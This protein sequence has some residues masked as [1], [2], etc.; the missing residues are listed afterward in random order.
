VGSRRDRAE[1]F[2][3]AWQ[4][5]LG[6]SSQPTEQLRLLR[7]HGL[8]APATPSGHAALATT[9]DLP[10]VV[11]WLDAFTAELDLLSGPAAEVA[12]SLL[13]TTYLWRDEHDVPVSL[14]GYHPPAR[15]VSRVGPV[16]T[17]P[18]HRRRGYA[19]A[20]TSA[21][22]QAAYDSGAVDVV[23]YT[24]ATNPTSNAVYERVGYVHE[25]DSLNLRLLRPSD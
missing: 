20:V 21:A 17:P 10:L 22:T 12:Q 16:F 11:E 14:A 7:C 4:A 5:L 15:E 3:A 6:A 1:A 19:G 9:D 24:D 23:L 18:E 8:L 2:A 13:G 25:S